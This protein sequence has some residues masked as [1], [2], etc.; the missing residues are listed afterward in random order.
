MDHALEEYV[1]L[2]YTP[3]IKNEHLGLQ[4]QRIQNFEKKL[5]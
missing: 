3:Y 2:L 4:L 1:T 5:F